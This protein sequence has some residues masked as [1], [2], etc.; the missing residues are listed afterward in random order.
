[1]LGN[2]QS[3][4]A[5]GRHA[6]SRSTYTSLEL[7]ALSEEG[8]QNKALEQEREIEQVSVFPSRTCSVSQVS[9]N[10]DVSYVLKSCPWKGN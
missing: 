6:Q 5:R 7:G 1:M 10:H 4:R 8:L 2:S 3:T 9:D